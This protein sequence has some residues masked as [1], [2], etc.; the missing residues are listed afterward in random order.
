[1]TLFLKKKNDL[2][3][4]GGA[5]GCCRRVEGLYCGVQAFHCGGFSWVALAVLPHKVLAARALGCQD[6]SSFGSPALEHRLNS[7]GTRA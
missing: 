1:M 5:F 4:F 2:F 6:F 7:C 3:I